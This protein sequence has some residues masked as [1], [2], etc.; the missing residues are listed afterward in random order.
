[1]RSGRHESQDEL[2]AIKSEQRH[3]KAAIQ[4]TLYGDVVSDVSCNKAA[5]KLQ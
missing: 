5:I 1:M 2:A 3:N 4:M